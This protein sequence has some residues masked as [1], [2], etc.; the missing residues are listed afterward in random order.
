MHVYSGRYYLTVIIFWVVFLL[1]CYGFFGYFYFLLHKACGIFSPFSTKTTELM[2]PR[3][4]QGFSVATPFLAMVCTSDTFVINV[5]NRVQFRRICMESL[6]HNWANVSETICFRMLVRPFGC[7]SFIIS[8]K[9]HNFTNS[10]F[11]DVTL[12]VCFCCSSETIQ[13]PYLDIPVVGGLI[14]CLKYDIIILWI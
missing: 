2:P 1:F 13:K 12:K 10:I 5:M 6:E 9:S 8:R 3:T 11:Y 14:L 7:C 4:Y